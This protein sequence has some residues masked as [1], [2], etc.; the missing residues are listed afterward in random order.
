MVVLVLGWGLL[1]LQLHEGLQGHLAWGQGAQNNQSWLYWSLLIL[2]Q[3]YIPN[4][5]I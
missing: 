4:F 3:A 2:K 1:Q 5:S